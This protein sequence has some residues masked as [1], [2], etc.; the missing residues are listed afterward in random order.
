MVLL[1]LVVVCHCQSQCN[2]IVQYSAWMDRAT[3]PLPLRLT[4]RTV[5]GREGRYG[6]DSD[7]QSAMLVGAYRSLPT[8]CSSLLIAHITLAFCLRFVYAPLT[9]L[10]QLVHPRRLARHEPSASHAQPPSRVRSSSHRR[11]SQ[12][13]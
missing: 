7:T 6:C 3:Q 9:R 10:K 5:A 13:R 8:R 12:W 2:C 11:R 1:W 4:G